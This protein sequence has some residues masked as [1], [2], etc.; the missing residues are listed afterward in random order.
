MNTVLDACAAGVP[1]VVA[2]IAFEQG[3]IAARVAWSGTGLVVRQG[4]RFRHR[5]TAAC[6]KILTEPGFAEKA[7]RMASEMALA[8]GASMA[9]DLI[10]EHVAGKTDRPIK[11]RR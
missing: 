11:V 5:L 3:A 4:M 10:L 2:P 9:A 6:R 7:R 8:G 1:V